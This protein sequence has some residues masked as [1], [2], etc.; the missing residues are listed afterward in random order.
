MY[1]RE[2]EMETVASLKYT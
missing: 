1:F 2:I